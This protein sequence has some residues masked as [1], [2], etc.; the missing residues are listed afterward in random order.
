MQ[1]RN[2]GKQ[3]TLQEVEAVTLAGY[4]HSFGHI[5]FDEH[6]K[7]E[8][9]IKE[10]KGKD[11]LEEFEKVLDNPAVPFQYKQ[12]GAFEEF[13]SDQAGRAGLGRMATFDSRITAVKTAKTRGVNLQKTLRKYYNTT[14]VQFA[15][16][17]LERVA[18]EPSDVINLFLNEASVTKN[19]ENY[20]GGLHEIAKRR[21]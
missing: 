20:R 3:I 2:L 16:D 17:I 15:K 21:H 14:K 4:F 10:G 5:F 12:K 8:L 9:D 1:N 13:I 18:G 19:P 11:L 7:S 6:I